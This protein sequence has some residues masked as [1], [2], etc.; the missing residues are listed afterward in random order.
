MIQVAKCRGLA[1]C[2]GKTSLQNKI[3]P[4]VLGQGKDRSFEIIQ[5]EENKVK[6]KKKFSHI[7]ES[8]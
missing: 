1:L 5:S 3:D 2:W 8:D 7:K 6:K 4:A